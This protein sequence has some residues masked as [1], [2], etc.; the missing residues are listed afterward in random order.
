MKYRLHP[1]L[2]SSALTDGGLELRDHSGATRSF[3]GAEAAI[4]HSV[5]E[6]ISPSMPPRAG[7]TPPPT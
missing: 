5:A 4:L 3:T 2:A 7:G 1:D 6:G